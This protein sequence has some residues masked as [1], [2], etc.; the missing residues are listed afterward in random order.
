[1][2]ISCSFDSPKSYLYAQNLKKQKRSTFKVHNLHSKYLHFISYTA[3]KSSFSA[4]HC[5]IY[6]DFVKSEELAHK[7]DFLVLLKTE[8]RTHG[9][10]SLWENI[11]EV[12]KLKIENMSTFLAFWMYLK[13]TINNSPFFVIKY[14]TFNV[15]LGKCARLSKDKVQFQDLQSSQIFLD[16]AIKLYILKSWSSK[17]V[18]IFSFCLFKWMPFYKKWFIP[19]TN[20]EHVCF[21][22]FM[23][24]S[25]GN[26]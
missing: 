16:Q 8:M 4:S 22:G 5:S 2:M 3:K 9:T 24:V 12:P 25:Y 20:L 23:H 13:V 15:L 7:Q 1:M 11:P 21:F 19:K 6:Q 18:P 26:N 17:V 14:C 10:L